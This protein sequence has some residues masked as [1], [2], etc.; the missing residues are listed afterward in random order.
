MTRSIFQQSIK[1]QG[2]FGWLDKCLGR[3]AEFFVEPPD[4]R[5]CQRTNATQHLVHP[6]FAASGNVDTTGVALSGFLVE[7]KE[8][9]TRTCK[10]GLEPA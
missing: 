8:M 7:Y 5:E 2:A 9:H 1:Q 6:V 10:I 4:H 3:N